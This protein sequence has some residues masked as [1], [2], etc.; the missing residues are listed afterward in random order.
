MRKSEYLPVSTSDKEM[1]DSES[2]KETTKHKSFWHQ[3]PR[4]E[5]IVLHGKRVLPLSLIF[6]GMITF[7]NL[8]TSDALINRVVSRFQYAILTGLVCG[9]CI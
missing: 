7:N 8:C 5:Y 1:E 6:V 3:F 4:A 9:L 2:G